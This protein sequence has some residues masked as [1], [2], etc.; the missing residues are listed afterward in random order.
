MS[1]NHPIPMAY[2]M[3]QR[4]CPSSP[5]SPRH[6]IA[7]GILTRAGTRTVSTIRTADGTTG[8]IRPTG[9]AR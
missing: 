5:P 3:E 2:A 4:A 7:V 1:H 9:G 8:S 6:L